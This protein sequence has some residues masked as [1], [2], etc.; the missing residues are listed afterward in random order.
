MSSSAHRPGRTG[1]V[2]GLLDI[3]TAKTA[4]LV[5]SAPNGATSPP[6]VIGSGV[7]ATRGLKAGV[8]VEMDGVEQA[9]RGA[10]S[11][12]ERSAGLRLGE[13]SLAVSCGR[14]RAHSFQANAAILEQTVG[15]SDVERLLQAGHAFA[16]RDGRALLDLRFLGFRIDGA[17]ATGNVHGIAGRQID[18][19]V[20]A[21]TADEAPLRNMVHVLERAGLSLASLVPS[22]WASGLAATTAEDREAG[23]LCIDLGAGTT[24][25]A[26]FAQGHLLSCDVLPVGGNHITFDIA[27]ALSTPLSEAE[28]IKRAYGTLSAGV[29]AH[30]EGITYTL[31]GQAG[32]HV[33]ADLYQTTA[34]HVRQLIE[35]RIASLLALVAE[36]I[37][38]TAMPQYCRS[39]IVL[40]GGSSALPGLAEF[41]AH[42]FARPV[43]LSV[44][45]PL[46]GLAEIVSGPAY[47]TVVG[48][49]LMPPGLGVSLAQAPG[50]KAAGG[51]LQRMG[52]WLR[53]SK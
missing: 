35:A 48:M 2:I 17:P 26:M 12:A 30:D 21:I 7:R 11:D 3:G 13:V 39:P 6:I 50:A 40:T 53:G 49:A 52:Q 37:E 19:D 24:Q 51:Y 14:L 16:R 20:M 8:V 18:A 46:E 32:Q 27:R 25:L 10:V 9:I 15:Q 1:E 47:A 38:R 36:R 4:C 31:A 34:G 22:P 23:V 5:V 29:E 43:R 45:Q 41:A 42:T 28:R 33:G 44:T